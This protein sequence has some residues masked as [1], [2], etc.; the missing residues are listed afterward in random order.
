MPN[1]QRLAE[2]HRVVP[3]L[4]HA[5]NIGDGEIDPVAREELRKDMRRSKLL[6]LRQK[7]TEISFA[8]LLQRE[9][10]SNIQVKGPHLGQILFGME[11]LRQSKDIDLLIE[12]DRIM[13]AVELAAR[14]GYVSSAGA[15]IDTARVRRLLRF[16]REIEIRDPRTG[17]AIELHWQLLETPPAGWDDRLFFTTPLTLSSPEYV[18]YLMLHGA[19]SH[20]H[21]MKWLADL[22]MI[23]RMVD[24]S[25]LR[26]VIGLARTYDCLPALAASFIACGNLWERAL[27]ERWLAKIDL[28]PSDKRIARHCEAFERALNREGVME[29]GELMARRFEVIR[30][31]PLFGENYPP[32][33][34]AIARRT[35]YWLARRG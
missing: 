10:I 13:D 16:H 26:S 7:A 22:A 2:R 30:D 12:E 20:W 27:V 9:G 3:L 33:L 24:E 17:C 34:P 19:A 25:V 21:R 29:R 6:G 4:W 11:D 31:A 35:A 5:L 28:P 23:A 15:P 14:S 8:R 1:P 18:L 32:R